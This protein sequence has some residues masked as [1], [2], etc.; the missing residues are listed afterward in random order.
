MKI[1]D[2]LEKG[3]P[4]ITDEDRELNVVGVFKSRTS[5]EIDFCRM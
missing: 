5:K 1:P 2:I 3:R 4:V